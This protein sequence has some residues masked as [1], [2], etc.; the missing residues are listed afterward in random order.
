VEKSAADVVAL[1]ELS[2]FIAADKAFV[3]CLYR[4][5]RGLVVIHPSIAT[6]D[7]RTLCKKMHRI[8]AMMM[9]LKESRDARLSH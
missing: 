6:N 2:L 8:K 9:T 4:S 5:V 1:L 7:E 3:A